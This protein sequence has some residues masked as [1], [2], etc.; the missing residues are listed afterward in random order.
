VREPSAALIALVR[1]VCF[2]SC[3]ELGICVALCVLYIV[4][5]SVYNLVSVS[6]YQW[7]LLDK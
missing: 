3:T 5:I 1:T 4:L 2:L 6:I 7:A